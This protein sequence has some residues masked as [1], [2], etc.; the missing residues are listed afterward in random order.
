MDVDLWMIPETGMDVG[1]QVKRRI[2]RER[3]EVW[4]RDPRSGLEQFYTLCFE[5]RGLFIH[6]VTHG[7][8]S[9]G[10]VQHFIHALPYALGSG[11]GIFFSGEI[12]AQFDR[13]ELT[14]TNPHFS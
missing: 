6:G 14:V 7:L 4:I 1:G 11:R 13:T 8:P 2:R 5:K 3:R 12:T 10:V 9:H